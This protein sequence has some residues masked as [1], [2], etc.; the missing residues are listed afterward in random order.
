[1]ISRQ[2]FYWQ[3]RITIR[4][5]YIRKYENIWLKAEINMTYPEKWNEFVICIVYLIY[6][7]I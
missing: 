5:K 7:V 2:R 4:D 1:M 6:D 3:S